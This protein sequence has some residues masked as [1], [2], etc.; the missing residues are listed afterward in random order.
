[1]D[2]DYQTFLA[3]FALSG[4]GLAITFFLSWLASRKERFLITWTLGVSFMALGV[5]IYA[6]YAQSMSAVLGALGYSILLTGLAFVY[7]A[8]R[9][10]RTGV[11]PVRQ[12][13]TMAVTSCIS[14]SALM[15]SGQNT[16]SIILLNLAA[17]TILLI[18]AWDYWLGRAENPLTVALLTGLYVVTGLSFL[19]CAALLWHAGE[20]QLTQA[21]AN[22]AEDLNIGTCLLTLAGIGALSLALNQVRVARGHKRAAETDLLTGLLNRRALLDRLG[23]ELKGPAS[24]VIFDLDRFKMINDVQGHLA[25][26]DVLR[27]FG[28]ILSAV[29]IPGGSRPAGFAARLGGEEFALL[30]PEAS[31]NAAEEVAEE[32]RQRLTEWRFAGKRGW[33]AATVSAGVARSKTGI[34]DF[35]ALLR[36]ADDALY[37]AKRDGRDRVVVSSEIIALA[38]FVEPCAKRE[39]AA[40]VRQGELVATASRSS[41]RAV[42]G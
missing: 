7:G 2:L 22:W 28:D 3:A 6:L 11:L 9:E 15:L 31:L 27:A 13:F 30:L 17:A 25:G 33:F 37:T 34:M 14:V 23:D 26:D 39:S 5:L 19:P 32:V 4:G 21:P 29:T 20:W 8:G 41:G 10:F 40:Y 18:T 42:A 24:L 16:A 38:P 35:D 12:M 36:D 1:M